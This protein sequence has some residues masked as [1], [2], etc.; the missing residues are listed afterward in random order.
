MSDIEHAKVVILGTGPA[1]CTAAIYAARAMLQPLMVAGMQP[2][3]QLTITTEV[4][5]YPG[6]REAVQGPWL[7]EQMQAQAEHL[8]TRVEYDLI[9]SVDLARRPF[10]L[11][12]DSGKRYSADALIIATGAQAKWLGIPSEEKFKG[13]GVSACATCDGFFFKEKKVVVVGGG[14]TAVEEALFLTNF[15]SQVTLV[16]RRDSLRADKTNQTRL[17]Q[18]PK[19]RIVWDSVVE[20]VVGGGE[21][22]HVT[23]V[24][25]KNIKSGAVETL[26]AD[27]LF[28]AIGHTPATEIFRG[29]ID[30]DEEGYIRTAPDSTKTSVPGVFAAG[31][32]KDRVFRQAVTAA[33]MGCMAALEAER[34]LAGG[35]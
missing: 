11:T 1:G 14:N 9:S 3:G 30:M 6:F 22:K 7:M 29:Q 31:D 2:G 13:F 17:E 12:G 5:N 25:V 18:N 4:E 27:G 28:V 26:P 34:F 23:G 32:V 35:H 19:T 20:E 33:G 21:P 8:G 10:A 16:H 15:A 24:K